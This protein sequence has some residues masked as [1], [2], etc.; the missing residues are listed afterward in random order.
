MNLNAFQLDIVNKFLDE[1]VT[2]NKGILGKN[3]TAFQLDDVNNFL[4]EDVTIKHWYSR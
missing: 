1:D 2:I 3:L 4:D